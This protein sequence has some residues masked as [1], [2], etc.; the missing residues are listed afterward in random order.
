MLVIA[1][2]FLKKSEFLG[3]IDSLLLL[4]EGVTLVVL[5]ESPKSFFKNGKGL[6]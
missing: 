5:V 6:E 3:S 2:K 1:R 4:P